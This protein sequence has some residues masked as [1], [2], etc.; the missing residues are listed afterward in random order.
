M[1]NFLNFYI[2]SPHNP[3]PS[4]PHCCT[5][6]EYIVLHTPAHIHT[7]K[8]GIGGRWTSEK[9]RGALVHRRVENTN[10]ANC[11]SSLKTLLNT[12]KDRVWC[13][14]SYLV[15]EINCS[16]PSLGSNRVV[17]LRRENNSYPVLGSDGVGPL[18]RSGAT[19]CKQLLSALQLLVN[20]TRKQRI[21]AGTRVDLKN[22]RRKSKK[23]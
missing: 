22:K 6:Y 3:I 17:A 5:L 11:I 9:V 1:Y 2:S 13:L 4:P 7:W 14:Y 20:L 10:M 18:R 19:L 8:G 23:S 16:L 15:H 21:N 12:S